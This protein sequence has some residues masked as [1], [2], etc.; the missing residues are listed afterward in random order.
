MKGSELSAGRSDILDLSSVRSSWSKAK[1]VFRTLYS[2]IKKQAEE[3][4]MVKC[5]RLYVEV[6][7]FNAQGVYERFGMTK[8]DTYNF[9]EQDFIY[10]IDWNAEPTKLFSLNFKFF[11]SFHIP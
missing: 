7:N 9:D 5:V 6:E 8:M 4:P 2:Q 10:P 11:S 3:D 1:G